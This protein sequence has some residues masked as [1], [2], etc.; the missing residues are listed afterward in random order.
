[1][2]QITKCKCGSTIAACQEP[3][4]YTNAEYQRDTRKLIKKGYTVEMVESG[5]WHFEDCTCEKQLKIENTN[6]PKNKKQ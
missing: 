4:C 2:V 5:M 3:F 6:Q 1:M